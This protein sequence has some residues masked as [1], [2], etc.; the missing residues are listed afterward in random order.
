MVGGRLHIDLLL[1]S[2][3]FSVCF[4]LGCGFVDN[5]LSFWVFLE[6]CGLSLVPSFFYVSDSSLQ[7]F[8]SSLLGYIVMSAMSSV[9]LMSG[10]IFNALYF[11]ILLGFMLKFG[12]FPFS[13]WVYRVFSGSNWVFIFL[14]SVV[15]KFPVLFFC[16]L[17][18]NESDIIL[19]WD[20][21]GTLLF[22]CFWFWCFSYSWKFIWCHISLASIATLI[23]SCFCSDFLVSGFIYF[24]Y[25]IWASFCLVYF[26][27]LNSEDAVKSS[28]WVYCFLLLITPVSL[29]LFYKLGVCFAIAYSSF[30]LLLSWCLYS[31][32]EQ[33]FLYKLGS[34]LF[35]S[36]IYN[37]WY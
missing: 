1:F 7:G 19:Y 27:L 15:S 31:F 34:D 21:G 22:C 25:A 26:S 16:Y 30:Y 20:C 24:Y 5:L 2:F 33:I 17:L 35:Y 23:V 36:H 14:L 32:S 37:N 12:L 3:F 11:F 8:Y 18:N 13:L 9:L 4:C 28:F 10:I 29:P 6:L